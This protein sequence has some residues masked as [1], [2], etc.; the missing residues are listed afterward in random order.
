VAIFVADQPGMVLHWGVGLNKV[1]EWLGPDKMDF[2]RLPTGTQPF[3]KASVDSPFTLEDGLNKLTVEILKNS[4]EPHSIS[5]VLRKDS[6][7]FNNGGQNFNVIL[8]EPPKPENLPG[9]SIGSMVNEIIQAE[10][11]YGSWTLMHRFRLCKQWLE[12]IGPGDLEG[13][14]WIYV[15]MRYSAARKLDWQRRY[16]TRPVELA[17]AQKE[18]TF[19]LGRLCKEAANSGIINPRALLRG[20]MSGLGKGGDHGQ[21]IRDEIL[22]IMHRHKISEHGNYMEQ[23][24][25][26]LHNNTTPDD[27]VICEAL[28]IYC[29][30]NDNKKY[31]EHLNAN[32]VTRERLASFERPITM[33]PMYLPHIIGDLEHYLGV[34]KSV[35]TASDVVQLINDSIGM[36]GNLSGVLNE[37]RSNIGHWDTILQLRRVTAARLALQ[38]E[39]D[40][41]DVGRYRDIVFLDIGLEI[42][43][44]TLCEKIIHLDLNVKHWMDM[45][46]L[47]LEHASTLGRDEEVNLTIQDWKAIHAKYVNSFESNGDHCL[48]MKA[49]LD[50][51]MRL[52]GRFVDFYT[53]KI[54]YK[55]RYL[56]KGFRVEDSYVN[57][58]T[59]EVIRGTIMFAVSMVLKKIDPHI[60]RIARMSPWQI[61]S[62][63]R[64]AQGR[65]IYVPSLQPIQYS[66]YSEPTIIMAGKV[67]GDEEIPEGVTGVFTPSELDALA[68][69]SV[70]ARNCNVFLAVCFDSEML[71][72]VRNYE[73][74]LVEIRVS[75]SDV[76]LTEIRSLDAKE[77]D[78]ERKA[79]VKKPRNIDKYIIGP[80]EFS[81]GLTGA[82][83]NNCAFLK[84]HLPSEFSVPNNIALPYG[85]CEKVLEFNRDI[86][87]Q[88]NQL[89]ESLNHLE[90]AEDAKKVLDQLKEKVMVLTIPQDIRN[91]IMTALRTLGIQESDWEAAWKAIKSVWAS[92]FNERAYISTLKAGISMRDIVM[93]VLCQ[94]V[95]SGDYAYVLHTK[96]PSTNDM[97]VIYGEI[98]IGM[99][100]TLVGAYEGRA[101]SFSVEKNSGRFV[102]HSYPNKSV[103]LFGSGFIFRSDSNSEDLPGFAGAGLF[104]SFVMKPADE[105]R[106]SYANEKLVNDSG[107]RERIIRKMK[108]VGLAVENA[109]DGQAQDI[110]GVIK[111]E[112]VYVVQSRPQV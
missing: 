62:P 33:E 63:G 81:E 93:A 79:E 3:D 57:I 95:V 7:W 26:K 8:K 42:Y 39:L 97:N 13:L 15:W 86:L 102:I 9:G 24:H 29:R 12:R 108:E 100:E 82:K 27:V 91:E 76:T 6:T 72:R 75:A 52:L 1:G 50:R 45:L 53:E 31:W 69:V 56:G 78:E 98:V 89:M 23:W 18:L 74:R 35:H 51:V 83:S 20:V 64:K 61:I 111:G 11:E 68:H 40:H 48:I 5:Y 104:D 25:Q 106:V 80:E 84:K 105:R 49:G 85:T 59:E 14:S 101:F 36:L 38:A 37:I 92:K 67:S 99:G 58:Y 46:A 77:A 107:F 41:S 28:I 22:E 103:A 30:T 17:H 87:E 110:E 19:C 47:Y 2:V 88:Y 66:K 71:T 73:N 10:V 34:L 70:R 32:G 112:Q 109:F 21:R 16:N 44:R 54:D 60:R 65:F 4:H 43:A 96:N 94:E 55:A 90:K